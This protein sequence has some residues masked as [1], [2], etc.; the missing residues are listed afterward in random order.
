MN[1]GLAGEAQQELSGP[2]CFD[3]VLVLL[4]LLIFGCCCGC[5]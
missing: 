1:P 3:M 5:S 2:V 4:V